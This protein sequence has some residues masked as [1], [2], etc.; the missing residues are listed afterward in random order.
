MFDQALFDSENNLNV[1]YLIDKMHRNMNEQV[2]FRFIF[3]YKKWHESK[4]QGEKIQKQQ[5]ALTWM[6]LTLVLVD[7]RI[8]RFPSVQVIP[9][10]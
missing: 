7:T 8:L 4:Q 1:T 10:P 3:I 9:S 6:K 5:D 2:K